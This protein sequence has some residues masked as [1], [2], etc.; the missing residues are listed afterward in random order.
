[1]I[2]S[3]VM[4]WG[5]KGDPGH[6]AETL[7]VAPTGPS[8]KASSSARPTAPAAP[9]SDPPDAP[10]G[11]SSLIAGRYEDRALIARGAMGEIRRVYD[12]RLR[13][14]VAMKLLS[15]ELI[16][17]F[18]A[19]TRFSNEIAITAGL[20]HPGIVAV[21][22]CGELD[23]R[24]WFTMK[25]IQG[26]TLDAAVRELHK[27]GP[28]RTTMALMR[29]LEAFRR[30]CE[31][32]AFAHSRHIIH[33][34]IKPSNLMLGAYGEVLVMDWGVAKR[35]GIESGP[36]GDEPSLGDPELTAFG[37]VVG[38]PQFM[39][40]EQAGGAARVGAR[41]DVYALG[42]VLRFVLVGRPPYGGHGR[43]ALARL[44]AGPPLPL[45]ECLA[46]GQT[47]IP[48]A[49]VRI[50][51]RAMSR[52]PAARFPDA[53]AL[54]RA[55]GDWV[56][57][58]RRHREAVLVL[59]RAREHEAKAGALR[60]NATAER[61]AASALV[62]D[63]AKLPPEV[64]GEISEAKRRLWRHEDRATELERDAVLAEV[65]WLQLVRT[66]LEHDPDLE[67]AHALLADHHAARL[68]AAERAHDDHAV[69]AQ[70]LMLR[71]HD[72]GR[73]TRLLSASGAV[74]LVTDPPGVEVIARR[75][76]TVDRKLVPGAAVR[77][78]ATPLREH[79]LAKGSYELTLR[80]P[81]RPEVRY[82]ILVERGGHWDGIPP[83]ES[84]PEPVVVPR[85]DEIPE[86]MVYVP[87]GWFW[88]GGDPLAVDSLPS[89]SIWVD[90]FL[91]GRFCVTSA[92]YLVYLNELV[93]AGREQEALRDAP[94]QALGSSDG[95]HSPPAVTR[96]SDGRFVLAGD[97]LDEPWEED[98]PIVR[99]DWLAARAYAAWLGERDGQEYR[100]PDELEWEKMARGVD[101]RRCAWGNHFE[102]SWACILGSQR[103]VPARTSVH[104]FPY[105]E[106]P[107]AARGVMG[108]VR[109]WC[110]NEWRPEG[111]PVVGHRLVV[112]PAPPDS[113][114]EIAARG[115]AWNSTVD[116]ARPAGRF[117]TKPSHRFGSLGF[118]LVASLRSSTT[119]R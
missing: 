100:L 83:G 103:G 84:E 75:Y 48:E 102:P 98:W 56:E 32:V 63:A 57:G 62:D 20:Q 74:S 38:T 95:S 25:E 59:A 71:Q 13:R 68:V 91:V 18:A 1:M 2:A 42:A 88:S 80:A 10:P 99:V 86:G 118:R 54:E 52:D 94:R 5:D 9:A 23:D 111:P 92:E 66:A 31:A 82:P 119:P 49:L 64:E 50:C 53:A 101:G 104:A 29:L 35:I 3:R 28:P 109:Q 37:D 114:G 4:G 85:S 110:Q 40:P 61:A 65:Q 47:R 78:G 90:G 73:Y 51:E 93:R 58:A 8:A 24:P 15:W 69:A 21:H 79:P 14:V 19:R 39:A 70:E 36:F 117:A 72:Q 41:S 76:E 108:N 43:E 16:D 44:R 17:D 115:G 89:R 87:S 96:S 112:A 81:G 55:L 46:P 60:A 7:R 77:L 6:R 105:D 30:I 34:D 12:H 11:R 26:G 106:S 116:L 45:E 113:A 97:D 22:D 67:E 107:Y 33:R 27:I